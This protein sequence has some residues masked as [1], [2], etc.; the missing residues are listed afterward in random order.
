VGVGTQ[1]QAPYPVQTPFGVRYQ[2]MPVEID[3]ALLRNIAEETGGMYFRAIDNST[4]K[5]IYNKID[6]LE[7]SK[8]EVTSYRSAAELF[9]N[10][11][12]AGLILI[13]LELVLSK[14]VFRKIP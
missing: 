10:W 14:T 12:N 8:I 6:R 7:K 1:G 3:E 4:L 11:L 5:N 2:M 13:L 9:S